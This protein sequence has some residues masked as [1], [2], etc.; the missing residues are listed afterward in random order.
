L[1]GLGRW[2]SAHQVAAYFALAF[3][4]SWPLFFLVLYVFPRSMALQGTVGSLAAFAPA[5]AAIFVAGIAE[6]ARIGKKRS[7]HWAAFFLT[8]V[9]AGAT[10]IFFAARV[11][12]AR[13][14]PPVLVFSAALA[15]LPAFIVSRAFSG[16]A[17]IRN[18]FRSLIA[19]KGNVFW[20]LLAIFIVPAIQIVGV[21]I[22]RFI[23]AEAASQSGL[24]V[25]VDP[26]MAVLLFLQG[27]FFAGGINEESGW[28]GFALSRL[29][30][31]HCPLVAALIVWIFWALW[32]LP[33][34]LASG[35][36]A[37]SIIMNR[38]LFNAMWSILFMWVFNRTQGS[39]LAPA[40][41]HPAMNASGNLLPRTNAATV[42]F[43]LLVIYAVVRD[44]MW[45]KA[46]GS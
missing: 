13:I 9:L 46:R 32:H 30:R 15:L 1:K 36:A 45:L 17:G 16:I 20:Y 40:L 11:R 7:A 6:P 25:T 43:A 28:R 39:L 4:F 26:V 23:D 21:V 3:L 33:M 2:I 35:D 22:T 12:G 18:L 29:Q 31:R 41:F 27:F 19:P 37:S 24:G 38:G 5:I 10:M 14:E 8:W 42:L 34:D 44:K